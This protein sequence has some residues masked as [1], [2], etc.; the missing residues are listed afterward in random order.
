MIN[1]QKGFTLIEMLVSLS[2][3]MI[4]LS[5]SFLLFRPQHVMVK[6]KLFFSTLQSDLYYAQSYALSHQM[7]MYVYFYPKH[8]RYY[9]SGDMQTGYIVDRYYDESIKINQ[10]LTPISFSIV[11]NGNVSEFATYYISIEDKN[12]KFTVQIGQGRF[13]VAK[14]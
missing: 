2:V 4:L 9:I 11:R 12:Y 6:E 14:L 8:K 1:N 5:I 13:Y 10:D 7:K 3:F